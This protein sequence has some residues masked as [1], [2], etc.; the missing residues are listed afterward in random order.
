M[1][2]KP[3]KKN[4]S[5]PSG[6]WS[7]VKPFYKKHPVASTILVLVLVI[8][9]AQGIWTIAHNRQAAHQKQQFLVLADQL[10][11]IN[12]QIIAELGEQTS[13]KT[14]KNCNYKSAEFG[15]GQRMCTVSR[16]FYYNL[17]DPSD[18]VSEQ[19]T[20][21]IYRTLAKIPFVKQ[22]SKNKY[23]FKPTLLSAS[24]KL[25]KEQ[26]CGAQVIIIRAQNAADALSYPGFI[27]PGQ[28]QARVP[29][30]SGELF[31]TSGAVADIF[32]VR[33]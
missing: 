28:D 14:E 7:K 3:S 30:L 11:K 23:D 4:E 20:E 25:S 17:D 27:L 22:A 5:K 33:D 24:F 29:G 13:S 6:W 9:L 1:K 8:L 32:P 18:K 16:Y 21:T 31:C 19:Q 15:R 26:R 12:D 10:D 2:K